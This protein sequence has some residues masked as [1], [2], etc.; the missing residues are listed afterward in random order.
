MT[1]LEYRERVIRKGGVR[2][3][4]R[5][6]REKLDWFASWDE[7][8][9]DLYRDVQPICCKIASAMTDIPPASWRQRDGQS[10]IDRHVD[11]RPIDAAVEV[12][13]TA[14]L[15]T[16]QWPLSM[17][18]EGNL[19][20][21]TSARYI[22]GRVLGSRGRIATPWPQSSLVRVTERRTRDR[23]VGQRLGGIQ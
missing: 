2:R 9:V 19:A 7:P 15:R 18:G 13:G 23:A 11:D 16:Q 21:D 12:L 22:V 3:N 1:Y 6:C 10:C 5:Y 4:D 17:P 20:I 14:S 8:S